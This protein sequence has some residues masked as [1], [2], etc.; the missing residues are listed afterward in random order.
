[1]IFVDNLAEILPMRT[2]YLALRVAYCTV[3]FSITSLGDITR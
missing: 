2:N 1:M 3:P